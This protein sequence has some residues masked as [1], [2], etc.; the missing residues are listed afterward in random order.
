MFFIIRMDSCAFRQFSGTTVCIDFDSN[1]SL[2]TGRDVLFCIRGC[3]TPSASFDFFNFQ[4]SRTSVLYD[5]SMPD[6]I[7][8]N[9]RR[10][11]NFV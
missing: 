4:R 8:L 9:N 3:C 7:A 2:T 1:S 5:K 6:I 11:I 10:N